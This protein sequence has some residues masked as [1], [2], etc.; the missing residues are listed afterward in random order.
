ME[1]RMPLTANIRP[2]ILPFSSP[3]GQL[4]YP[5]TVFI[6]VDGEPQAIPGYLTPNE[7]ELSW[8]NIS[9]KANTEKCRSMNIRRI[10]NPVGRDEISNKR[11]VK[12]DLRFWILTIVKLVLLWRLISNRI[13]VRQIII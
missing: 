8:P 11:N 10:L 2:M 13:I 4:S 3:M 9:E 7:F 1:K 5:T 6:P 12:L